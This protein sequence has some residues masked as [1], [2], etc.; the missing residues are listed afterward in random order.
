MRRVAL[1]IA[2]V[3]LLILPF[4]LGLC[5]FRVDSFYDLKGGQTEIT[6]GP[7]VVSF[8]AIR[9]LDGGQK[10][11]IPGALSPEFDAAKNVHYAFVSTGDYP[12]E[13]PLGVYHVRISY[14]ANGT[15]YHDE[16]TSDYV[17]ERKFG[18]HAPFYSKYF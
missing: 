9:C 13:L 18:F 4:A 5:A 11:S 2:F 15:P 3:L 7:V 17:V 8:R 14:T 1:I 12:V 6:N 16:V 10:S